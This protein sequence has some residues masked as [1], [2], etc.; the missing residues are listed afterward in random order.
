VSVIVVI[1]GITCGFFVES[2]NQVVLWIVASLYGGYTAA[3]VLKWYWWRFNAYGY[4]WG[5]VSGILTSLVLLLLDSF[6]FVPFLHN[7]PLPYN[8]SMNAF[9]LIFLISIFGCLIATFMTKPENDEILISFYKSVRP[10]GFW[11]PVREKILLEEPEFQSNK[12]F[13][14]DMFNVVIGAIWQITLMALPIFLVIHELNSFWLVLLVLV[15]TT[16]ILKFNWWDKLEKDFGFKIMQKK[17]HTIEF[18][19]QKVENDA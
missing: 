15:V 6:N 8:P 9:P 1:V 17:V 4:F 19:K 18:E 16:V 10:W 11:K 3:N 7:W 14:R 2:I 5:M 12:N 13:K